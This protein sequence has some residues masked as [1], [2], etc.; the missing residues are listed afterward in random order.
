[1]ASLTLVVLRAS[2]ITIFPSTATDLSLRWISSQNSW[3]VHLN[4][5]SEC[6]LI[7]GQLWWGWEACYFLFVL[8]Y[9]NSPYLSA[10]NIISF[11]ITAASSPP[12]WILPWNSWSTCFEILLKHPSNIIWLSCGEKHVLFCPPFNMA[13]FHILVTNIVIGLIPSSLS[14]VCLVDRPKKGSVLCLAWG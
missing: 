9:N 14:A 5:L 8:Q 6:L 1:M 13:F 11:V 4:A 10:S 7:I 12:V 2:N 3:D